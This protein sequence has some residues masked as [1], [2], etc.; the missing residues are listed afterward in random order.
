MVDGWGLYR[1]LK[2]N[3]VKDQF[4]KIYINYIKAYRKLGIMRSKS[5]YT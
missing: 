5:D 1:E 3:K 2:Y 4:E